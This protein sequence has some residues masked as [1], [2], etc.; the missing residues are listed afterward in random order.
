[1][2]SKMPRNGLADGAR[3]GAPDHYA[4]RVEIRAVFRNIWRRRRLIVLSIVVGALLAGFGASRITPL[5]MSSAKVMLDGRK[6]YYLT[7]KAVISDLDITEQVVNSEVSVLRSNILLESVI[8]KVGVDRLASLDPATQ[9]P[10]ISNRIKNLVGLGFAPSTDPTL[11]NAAHVQMVERLVYSIRQSLT[12]RREGKS[13]VIGVFVET[14]NPALSQLLAEAISEKYI[15]LQVSERQTAAEQATASI[16]KQVIEMR[17][18]VEL[19]ETSVQ[20]NRTKNLTTEG[21][22]AQTTQQQLLDLNSRLT[23]A[24]ADFAT[25]KARY[26]HLENI[27]ATQGVQAAEAIVT[28]ALVEDLKARRLALQHDDAVWAEYYDGTNRARARL[29]KEIGRLDEDIAKEIAR[30]LDVTRGEADT[31][32]NI[33]KSLA[34]SLN[35]L[36]QRVAYLKNRELAT[37]EL[38]SK[39]AA[40]RDTYNVLLVRLAES[41]A[42]ETFQRADAKLVE[43]ATIPGAPSFPRPKLLVALGAMSGLVAGLG[44]VFFLELSGAT[45]RSEAQ[46]EAETGLPVF[47]S[48]PTGNWASPGE[49]YRNLQLSASSIFAE[50]MRQLRT[51]LPAKDGQSLLVTSSVPGEGKTTTTI[52]LAKMFAQAHKSVIVIDCDLR[53]AS[54]NAIF[55]WDADFDLVDYINGQCPLGD[56]I[57]SDDKLDFD[58]LGPIAPDPSVVDEFSDSWLRGMVNTLTKY[59]DVVLLDAPPVLSVSEPIL[60]SK[61]VDKT[62]YLVRWDSTPGKAVLKGLGSLSE[63][64]VRP[65][66]LVFTM[67]DPDAEQWDYTDGYAYAV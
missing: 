59:Y 7:D 33:E 43:L 66:G 27:L 11:A 29:A 36:E 63:F 8:E 62:I 49:A 20:D 64:G 26:E 46:L 45:I 65:S 25:A 51:A 6:V 47:A 39:A 54:M 34:A 37:K 15:E 61:A 5:Y 28:T 56:A 21:T 58:L 1:M 44:A 40:L 23:L 22:S 57:Y 24:R 2:T 3:D 12:V 32:K 60:I 35:D 13:L 53:R 55:N 52:A 30:Y 4:D 38:Q 17:R 48:V 16:E 31:A 50:R 67:V 10:S 18:G 14:D 19:A 41:R 9:S 42:Q